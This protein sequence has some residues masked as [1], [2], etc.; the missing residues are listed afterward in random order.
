M[1]YLLLS[2]LHFVVAKLRD[3]L[4]R[5]IN[6]KHEEKCAFHGSLWEV[7][8]NEIVCQMKLQRKSR[9]AVFVGDILKTLVGITSE[10]FEKTISL[11]FQNELEW[12]NVSLIPGR[13]PPAHSTWREMS[14][15]R[16]RHEI[17]RQIEWARRERL[18]TRLDKCPTADLPISYPESTDFLVSGWSPVETLG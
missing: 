3:M 14:Y 18:G 16:W 12:R 4:P 1:E 9:C 8:L 10:E 7:S 15:I 13:F 17:L 5:N 6:C 11:R 2:F